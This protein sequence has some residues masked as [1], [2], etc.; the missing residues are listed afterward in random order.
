MAK[1][2]KQ[3]EMKREP[4]LIVTTAAPLLF[5]TR[6]GLKLCSHA[7]RLLNDRTARQ[8]AA[9]LGEPD[10]DFGGMHTEPD[11]Q[12]TDS[13]WLIGMYVGGDDWF[14]CTSDERKML[15]RMLS[16]SE[17]YP[18]LLLIVSIPNPAMDI[19]WKKHGVPL[20]KSW[21]LTEDEDELLYRTERKSADGK[22]LQ[23]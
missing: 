13:N 11:D 21:K 4:V 15:K 9:Y 6:M 19:M 18:D 1:Q 10:N 3:T 14:S 7:E 2:F 16:A 23:A 17:K 20:I 12:V 5:T 8:Y 22:L